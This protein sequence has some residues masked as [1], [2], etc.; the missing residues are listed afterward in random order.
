M[1]EQEAE[2]VIRNWVRDSRRTLI[3]AKAPTGLKPNV[4]RVGVNL[5]A[6]GV[7]ET[8]KGPLGPVATAAPTNAADPA[9]H[10]FFIDQMPGAN[11]EHPCQYA[12]VHASKN[13]TVVNS[14]APLSA[15]QNAPLIPVKG[16]F[17]EDE[18]NQ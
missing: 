18:A 6:G 13:I 9:Q 17:P 10:L 7:P 11:W 14:T 1:T 15:K 16:I 5:V 2:D 3:L 4:Y 12:F 8:I